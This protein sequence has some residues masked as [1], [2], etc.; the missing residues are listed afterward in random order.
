MKKDNRSKS[1]HSKKIFTSSTSSDNSALSSQPLE[2]DSADESHDTVILSE[3]DDDNPGEGEQEEE[4]HFR[5]GLPVLTGQ[6]GPN[7]LQTL[8]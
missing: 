5:R 3:S 1:Y 2:G 4:M 6:G 7:C 8:E